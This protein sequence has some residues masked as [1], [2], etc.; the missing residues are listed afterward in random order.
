M[1]DNKLRILITGTSS[2]FG[3]LAAETLARAGHDVYAGMRNPNGR[4]ANARDELTALKL[5]RG[6][7][8]VLDLDV[9]SDDSVNS[10]I[11]LIH[12]RAGGIDVLI[13][14]AGVLG[15]GILEAFTL[16]DI[17]AL[18][19]V[20]V[21]GALR[22]NRAVLP[23]MHAQNRGLLVHVTSSA[24]RLVFPFMSAYASSKFALE[25]IAEGYH[26]EL[27]QTGIESIIVQPGSFATK[28]ASNRLT[29]SDTSRLDKYA[30]LEPFHAGMKA[31]LES[32]ETDPNAPNPQV[33]ADALLQLVHAQPGTR[34]LRTLIDVHFAPL[35]ESINRVSAE[36]QPHVLGAMGMAHFARKGSTSAT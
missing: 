22:M 18:Y 27:S 5:E 6:S 29:P 34:P 20:N 12:G 26:Y 3:K 1:S 7:I 19:D 30:A 35:V 16:E 4:N 17:R 2:G 33:I 9:T 14:N 10:A 15:L 24:G 36:A 23:M 11:A 21:F 25:A 28:V 32:G 13:N 8:Q 31:M